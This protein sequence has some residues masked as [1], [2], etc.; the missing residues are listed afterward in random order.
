MFQFIIK[1]ILFLIPTLIIISIV[2]FIIIQLPPG[3][4]LTT[5]IATQEISGHVASESEIATLEKRYGLDQSVYIQYFKWINN[6]FQGDLGYSFGWQQPVSKLIGERLGLTLIISLV[7]LFFSWA[8]AFPI[9]IYSAIKHN[10][11]GDYLVTFVGFIGL[12]APSF[13]LAL[14][15]MYLAYQYFGI[16]VGGLFS[17]EYIRAAWSWGKFMDLLDHLWIPVILLGTSGAAALIRIM[18]NNLLDELEKPYV[19]TARVKGVNNIKLIIKY[20]VRM[21][22]IPFVSTAGWMLPNLISESM[23]IAVVIS[24]PTTGPLLLRALQ[25]QD[26]Y[27][28]GSIILLTAV[29][30]VIGTLISDL[31]LVLVDPR[32]KFE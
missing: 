28:A 7:S 27:L 5:Y 32:I 23:I 4:F 22:L 10:T 29:L 16:S 21:A 6:I 2:S 15:L 12:S 19:R 24:L 3:N 18:R 11:W 13:I 17:P 31:C 26:M 1:R 25:T 30:T 8:V 9:G 14:I 20:P